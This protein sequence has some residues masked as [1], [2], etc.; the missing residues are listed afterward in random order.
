MFLVRRKSPS[1]VTHFA[2]G[3]C[4]VFAWEKSGILQG[5]PARS[6]R[7][8]GWWSEFHLGDEFQESNQS[9]AFVYRQYLSCSFVGALAALDKA[10][11]YTRGSVF[12][13]LLFL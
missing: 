9:R 7:S 2:E 10:F 5:R 13:S 11:I 6:T 8:I 1:C 3:G 12:H 4:G